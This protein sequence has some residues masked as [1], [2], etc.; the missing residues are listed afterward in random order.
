MTK[1]RNQQIIERQQ[2]VVLPPWLKQAVELYAIQ[3]GMKKSEVFRSALHALG[4]E[5]SDFE[6]L[7]I[8]ARDQYMEQQEEVDEPVLTEDQKEILARLKDQEKAIFS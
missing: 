1:T 4:R 3:N 6:A 8:A 7:V 2:T 5:D